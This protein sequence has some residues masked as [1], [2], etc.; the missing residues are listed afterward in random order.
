MLVA[1][2]KMVD[3]AIDARRLQVEPLGEARRRLPLGGPVEEAAARERRPRERG[4]RHVLQ[5][6]ADHHQPL[7]APVGRQVEQAAIHQLARPPAG[8]VLALQPHRAGRDRLD[9]EG[10]PHHL[11]L[12]RAD[13]AGE[14]DDLAPRHR[15]R[16]AGH[17]PRRRRQPL[18][19]QDLLAGNAADRREKLAD[20]AAGHQP[21]QLVAADA[22]RIARRHIAPVAQHGDAVADPLDLL[23]AVRDVDDAH[24]LAFDLRD[25][26]EELLRLPLRQR[27]GRLVEDQ[28]AQ[29]RAERL[30]DLH[31]LLLGAAQI[32]HPVRRLQREAEPL[33][34]LHRAAAQAPAVEEA[35]AGRLGAEKNV[36]LDR[37]LRDQREFLE[38]RG[39]ADLARLLDGI[40]DGSACP[41]SGSRRRS[42]SLRRRGWRSASI[43]RRRSRRTGCAPRPPSARSR[44]GRARAR[45][46]IASSARRQ[47]S[48]AR[49]PRR[50]VAAHV[51]GLRH[52]REVRAGSLTPPGTPAKSR[53]A[54]ASRRCRSPSRSPASPR[55]APGRHVFG[56]PAPPGCA[57]PGRWRCGPG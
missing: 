54:P 6:G 49:R 52:R 19:A 26:A 21:H 22:A 23:H 48:A 43:C 7:G 2:G 35:A 27:G 9:A 29:L 24:A 20:D 55:R 12:A 46:D 51:I 31:H 50:E 56:S 32:V 3:R 37:H 18:D 25:E 38:H 17:R 16:C 40:R 41:R 30:G 15:K 33:D 39:N 13:E 5:A 45:R 57:R 14:A 47:R 44:R 1:A 53:R 11:R 8:H 28:H 36:L 42:A 4:E 34:D 10:G